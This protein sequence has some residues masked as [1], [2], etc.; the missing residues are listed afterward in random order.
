MGKF[1]NFGS[2]AVILV[3]MFAIGIPAAILNGIGV[4]D[5]S[6]HSPAGSSGM[7]VIVVARDTVQERLGE[8]WNIPIW[9]DSVHIE[10]TNKDMRHQEFK[11]VGH[12]SYFKGRKQADWV[13]FLS[14]DHPF[15][16]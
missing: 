8:E 6:W 4:L 16:P 5:F 11:V 1:L 13:V 9:A 15:P 12:A 14:Y 7:N 2:T 10:K 3:V